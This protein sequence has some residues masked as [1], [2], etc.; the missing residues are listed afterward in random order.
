MR[1]ALVTQKVARGD[2]QG[3]VNYEI[4]RH[5][6][7]C[8]W[9]VT[10]LTADLAADL[11]ELPNVQW[12]AIP[13]AARYT[14]LAA[15]LRFAW[16]SGRWLRANRRQF[17]VVHVNGFN[18]LAPSDVN[19]VHFVHGA[20]IQSPVHT[21]RLRND[22]YGAYQWLYTRANASLEKTAFR[23]AG[24][25]I[26][27]SERVRQE[28]IEIG[29]PPAQIQVVLNGVDLAEF[30]PGTEERT[31]LGL[32]P[33]VPL[34]LFVGDIRTPRKNL[35]TILKALVH[36]PQMHLAV[37]GKPDGSP[38]PELAAQLDLTARVHFLG[39]RRDVARL[40]RA[41]DCF[42]FP[43]RYEACSLVLLEALASGLPVI[44]ADT[45]GGAEIVTDAC[46][47][48]LPDPDDV[49]A[50]SAAMQTIWAIIGDPARRVIMRDAAREV[51]E[52]HSWTQMAE[53]YLRIYAENHGTQSE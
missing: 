31:E 2:G 24:V 7:R 5:A 13:W 41:A 46:G 17:D 39:Y 12:I 21:A 53:E 38:F 19:A 18:T 47:V 20:W 11:R 29:V 23:R 1:L 34:G 36:V 6:A 4:A 9:Q 50:L 33:E 32:P 25:V 26:A 48:R 44:T 14:A 45:A 49:F 8:G 42:V 52:K 37:V 35:D 27:V 10:L 51:A 15:E 30:H 28:L 40:M 43:S 3:R 22:L 16:Q